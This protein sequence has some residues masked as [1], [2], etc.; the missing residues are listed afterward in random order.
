MSFGAMMA[1]LL[2]N[3]GVGVLVLLK[4][5]TD[6]KEDANIVGCVFVIGI[7]A[8]IIIDLLGIVA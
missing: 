2:V 6:K 4:S 1:G 8:G 5:N 3:S 7:I